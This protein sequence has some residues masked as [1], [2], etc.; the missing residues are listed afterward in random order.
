[1]HESLSYIAVDASLLHLFDL[2]CTDRLTEKAE[3]TY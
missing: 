3:L 1:M 2:L